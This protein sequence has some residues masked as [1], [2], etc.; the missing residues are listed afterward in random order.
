MSPSIIHDSFNIVSLSILVLVDIISLIISIYNIFVWSMTLYILVDFLWVVVIPESVPN[1]VGIIAI[2]H[3][4]TFLLLLAPLS[5]PEFGMM[6]CLHGLVESNTLVIVIR[7][8]WEDQS[9]VSFFEFLNWITFIPTRII[10]PPIIMRETINIVFYRQTQY[11]FLIKCF[12]VVTQSLLVVFN[13]Y[14][15]FRQFSKKKKPKN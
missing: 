9:N 4:M 8:R 5:Y 10:I 3:L 14:L 1:R 11:H 7:R 6:A 15:I 12:G 13:S 2:H